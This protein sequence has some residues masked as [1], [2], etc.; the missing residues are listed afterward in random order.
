MSKRSQIPSPSV[1]YFVETLWRVDLSQAF[2]A[3][4]QGTVRKRVSQITRACTVLVRYKDITSTNLEA[5][6]LGLLGLLRRGCGIVAM[7]FSR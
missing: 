2:T 6:V 4:S 5:P 1:E 3:H 7:K